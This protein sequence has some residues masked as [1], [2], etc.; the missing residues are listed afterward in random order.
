MRP[1]TAGGDAMMMGDDVIRDLLVQVC[2]TRE[3]LRPGADLLEEGILDS[4][5]MIDLLEGLE[6]LGIQIQPTRVPRDAFRTV[7]G[8]LTL[9][10]QAEK[11]E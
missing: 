2:G 7:E 6:D 11:Q 5:A 3:A 9:C 10:R 1:E 8:I 4:L